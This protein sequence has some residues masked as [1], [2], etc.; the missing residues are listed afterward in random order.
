MHDLMAEAFS[1][2]FDSVFFLWFS[3]EIVQISLK[4]ADIFHKV[5]SGSV[6]A[7]GVPRAAAFPLAVRH[8]EHF[9]AEKRLFFVIFVMRETAFVAPSA[10]QAF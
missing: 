6:G 7:A 9:L 10:S 3:N 5:V 2:H 8:F 1:H 4:F